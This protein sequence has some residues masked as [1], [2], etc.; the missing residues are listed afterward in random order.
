M[1]L[2]TAPQGARSLRT[3]STTS[4]AAIQF[5]PA[6]QPTPVSCQRS[7]LD[8]QRQRRTGLERQ[9]IL[10]ELAELVK[11]IERLLAILS[12]D[13]LVM[14]MVVGELRKGQQE[15]SHA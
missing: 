5:P 8:M 13:R 14:Q 7:I 10:D 15:D 6:L 3:H 1:C 11:L 2:W 4:R 12:S 9:K